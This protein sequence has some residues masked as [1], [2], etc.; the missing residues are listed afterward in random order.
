[1]LLDCS[2]KGLA[3]SLEVDGASVGIWLLVRVGGIRVATGEYPCQTGSWFSWEPQA[4][5]WS[6]GARL[7]QERKEETSVDQGSTAW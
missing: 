5:H 7:Q 6:P 1:M 4:R 3:L 2:R